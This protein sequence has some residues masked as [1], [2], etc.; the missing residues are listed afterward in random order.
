MKTKYFL[1]RT[2]KCPSLSIKKITEFLKT[3][4]P[5]QKKQSN[6]Q[7]VNYYISE[8]TENDWFLKIL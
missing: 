3:R 2:K 7:D 1:T 8:V 5:F 4:P 6:N